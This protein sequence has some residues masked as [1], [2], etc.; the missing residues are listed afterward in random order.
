[1][2]QFATGA[3]A[4]WRRR[5]GHHGAAASF[6]LR[7]FADARVRSVPSADAIA[8]VERRHPGARV[9][10][11]CAPGERLSDQEQDVGSFRYAIV[12]LAAPTR[13]ALER[14]WEEVRALLRFELEGG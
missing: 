2:A 11:L 6:V 7:R 4:G 14:A 5:S 9:H 1:M 13:E 3:P 8:G 10:V 12:N